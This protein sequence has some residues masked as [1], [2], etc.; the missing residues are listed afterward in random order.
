[1]SVERV[2]ALVTSERRNNDRDTINDE[3]LVLFPDII[4]TCSGMVVKWIMGGERES[5]QGEFSELQIWRLTGGSVYQ[6]ITGTVISLLSD[7]DDNV[8]EYTVNPPLPFQT[9]DILG[10]FQPDETALQLHYDSDD[11]SSI[12]YVSEFGNSD[13]FDV[14]GENVDTRRGLPLVTVEIGKKTYIT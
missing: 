7:E 2:Y 11:D 3:R 4:F 8:Y 9:G 12:Y 10:L 6:K 1:M 5:F 13:V 14:N